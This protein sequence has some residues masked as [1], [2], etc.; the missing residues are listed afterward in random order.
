M[1]HNS[2]A[3]STMTS[4]ESGPLEDM[5]P[6]L[7]RWC[8]S[9]LGATAGSRLLFLTAPD[10][11]AGARLFS[12]LRAE[13]AARGGSSDFLAVDDATPFPPL[14]R[15]DHDVVVYLSMTRSV[16]REELYVHLRDAGAG[17]KRFYRAFGFS[18]ELFL[19]C[20]NIDQP[21]LNELNRRLISTAQRARRVRVTDNA[22]TDLE[23][24]LG[25]SYA[26]TNCCG[27]FDG[28][29]AGVTPP[30]EVNTYSP[31]VNGTAVVRGALFSN[32]W[33]AGDPRLERNPVSVEF[34][35][36]EVKSI[37]CGEPFLEQ[38]LRD[39]LKVPFARRVGEVG[40]G[41]NEGIDRFVPFY[42]HINER[43][44]GLHLGLGSPSQGIGRLDWSCPLH[45]DLISSGCDIA[46][47]GKLV[48][49]GN[50]WVR[51]ALDAAGDVSLAG[52][53]FSSDAL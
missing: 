9:Y 51:S 8:S 34:E 33:F 21:E 30:G 17:G 29:L 43:F 23:I 42:S 18:E 53:V 46:F 38:V 6:G 22:G 3:A 40:F 2:F 14:L 27:L 24:V 45:L 25:G 28:K 7:R 13:I 39:F 10:V 19:R 16:H 15:S 47:D 49:G 32:F 5:R 37:R 26:W 4:L 20:F 44:P 35:A 31:E 11:R 1:S 41:T 48:F 36:S 50:R 12:E 52:K